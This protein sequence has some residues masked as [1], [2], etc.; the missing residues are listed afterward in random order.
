MTPVQ[1]TLTVEASVADVPTGRQHRAALL[2]LR[3]FGARGATGEE[4]AVFCSIRLAATATTRLE[5]M[6]VESKKRHLFPVPLVAKSA[7]KERATSS[8]RLAHVWHLTDAGQQVARAM[9]EEAR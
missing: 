5:E 6:S 8:G 9:E 3:E 4:V 2:A 7:T 1:L